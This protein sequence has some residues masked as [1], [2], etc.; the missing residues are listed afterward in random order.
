MIRVNVIY[1][2][3]HGS[4]VHTV[5]MPGEISSVD[6]PEGKRYNAMEIASASAIAVV[7]AQLEFPSAIN[8][9]VQAVWNM[10]E[11]T[12]FLTRVFTK[13]TEDVCK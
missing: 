13:M 12:G 1:S 4:G 7:D 8:H 10:D 2:S 5:D 3:S 11:R 6:C 9:T